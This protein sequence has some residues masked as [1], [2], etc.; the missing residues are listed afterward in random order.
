LNGLTGALSVANA[1]AAGATVTIDDASTGAK[2]IA[3]FNPTNFSA[4]AGVINTIQDINTTATPTFGRLTVTSNQ[5]TN[6]MLL[7]NNTAVAPSGNLLDLQQGG[8]SKFSVQPNGNTI[9]TGTINGQTISNTA[10]LTGTLAVAGA[11]TL[12]GVL[13]VN[14]GSVN[15]AGALNITP[16]GTLTVGATGQALALQGNTST[17]LAVVNGGNTTTVSFQAPAANVTYRFATTAAGNYD[18]CTTAGNCVGAGGGVTTL[19]GTTNRLAK[20]TGGVTVGDSSITD[21]GTTVTTTASV[22]IQGSSATVGVPNSQTGSLTLAYGSANFTGTVTP[23]ALSANRTYAL[24][25]ADGTVC[26][27]SGNC[28]GG[29]GGGAN[30]ALSNLSSVAINTSLLPGNT[31]VDLGSASAPFR[32]L[33]IAGGSLTPGTN[34]FE[35]TGIATAPRTI[36]LPD[37]SG[38]VCLNNSTNCGFLTGAG[39]AFVQNGNTLGA[40]ANLGTNDGFNLNLRTSGTTRLTVQS[41]GDVSF[42]NNVL[43]NGGQL[44]GT[45]ALAINPAGSLTAGTA[46]QGLTLQGNATTTVTASDSGNTTTVSFQVPTANVTYRFATTATGNYDVCT[47]AGN[48]V[49]TGGGVS[50]GGGTVGTIAVFTGAQ[51]IGDSL[52][53]Q[54]GGTVGV[55]GN[56]NLTAGNQYRINGSQISSGNLSNDANLAKLNASQTFTGNTVA[57]QNVSDSTNAF[58]IQNAT[59]NRILTVDTTGGQAVLGLASTLDGKLTFSN[60]GNANTITIVPGTPTA[61]RTLTLPNASGILCTDSGNCAGVGSTLQTG[62]NFSTGGTTPKIKVNNTLLG[63]DIQDA[64]TTIS[65]NLFNVRASNGAGL[66]QVMFGVGNTGQITVQNSSN[67]TTALRLLT[68][69]STSVLTGDTQNGQVILGQGGTL[70]GTLV[71]NNATNAN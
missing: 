50:T 4:S 26:L 12:S 5:A 18:V 58:N 44:G 48:C 6:P 54:S 45:G 49:G 71:F 36:T 16:G 32:N 39:T 27:S 15:S 66:G 51:A 7:V 64:D 29:G 55:N 17:S 65:A 1:S 60:I 24:P 8:S 35:V 41:G 70:G 25:D 34:N 67:S 43:I 11:T 53:S 40:A 30:T 59:G 62:Y 22:V 52:L 31:T 69:G 56:L 19:G 28:L 61:N 13:N 47:T 10:S 9:V 21:N 38:T 42:S 14:G 68:Q 37:S 57:F 33:F 46:S 2:G 63:V 20:F 23:G 3:S